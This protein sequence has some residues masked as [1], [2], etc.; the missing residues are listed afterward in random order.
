MH[1]ANHTLLS[2]AIADGPARSL[3]A[4]AQGCFGYDPALPDASIELVLGHRAVAL[5]DHEAQ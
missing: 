5:L 3:D 1:G 2:A 4:A